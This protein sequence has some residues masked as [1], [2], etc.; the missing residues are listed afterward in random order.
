MVLHALRR[1]PP[2]GR[3]GQRRD[4]QRLRRRGALQLPGRPDSPV[5]QRP[6]GGHSCRLLCKPGRPAR[7]SA[8]RTTARQPYAANC[9]ASRISFEAGDI[10][11]QVMSF[12]SPTPVEVAVQGVSLA[13]RLRLRAEGADPDW[14]SSRFLARSSIRAG[15]RL[16][17]PRYHYRPRARRPVR[18]D[19][20][21]RGALRGAGHFLVALHPDPN[22]WRDPNSGNAFQIQVELPQNRMQSAAE[23]G[24]L[25]VMRDGRSQ[26][27]LSDI[28]VL[29]PGHHARPDRT[30]Q[31]PARR[32]PH[33]AICT[34]SR[35]A[36]LLRGSTAPSRPPARR[37]KASRVRLRGEIPALEQTHLRTAH[38]PAPGGAGRSSFCWPRTSSRSAWRCRSC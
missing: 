17:H 19:H 21:G 9:P 3:P 25:P 5:H 24:N 11:S 38:R 22:Y 2:R 36:K 7:R 23:V 31:R 16:P 18:T 20:G 12:G 8:A 37:R 26:P 28:A 6:A 27:R 35:W 30:L 4:H 32:Q 1:H 14:P 10:V 34:A 33:G 13:G 15:N 29:K